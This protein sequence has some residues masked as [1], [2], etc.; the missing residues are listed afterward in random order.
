MRIVLHIKRCYRVVE[1]I[2]PFQHRIFTY[3]DSF[4]FVCRAI[5]SRQLYIFAHVDWGKGILVTMQLLQFC[6]FAH[7]ER[8]NLIL[9]AIQRCQLRIMAYQELLVLKELLEA[10]MV[11]F[12]T[13]IYY[14]SI[15]AQLK[16]V[17]DRFYAINE[18][19]MSKKLK[20]LLM[21]TCGDGNWVTEPTIGMFS[22]MCKYLGWEMV[23]RLY[24]E[25]VYTL[26]DMRGKDY[27]DRAF[28]MGLDT[29]RYI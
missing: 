21:T 29:M 10:D 9:G 13:P 16:R 17:I 19:L 18:V 8:R 26:E 20:V 27:P 12:A 22:C 6:I 28:Q 3:I 1:T 23:G 4:Q 14:F 7:I 11:V 2:Q 24:A 5:Q 25:Y 15:L